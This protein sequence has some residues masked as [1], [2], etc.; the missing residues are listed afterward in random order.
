[1]QLPEGGHV[2]A[3]DELLDY[4]RSEPDLSLMAYAAVLFGAYTRP[5]RLPAH[6]EHPGTTARLAVLAEAA[7]EL[8]ATPTQVVLAWLIG[9]NPPITPIVGVSSVAQLDECLAAVDLDLP[10]ALRRRLDAPA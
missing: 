8:G 5:D 7:A 2:H 1:V 10:D 4:V 3:T 9:G 6:Y